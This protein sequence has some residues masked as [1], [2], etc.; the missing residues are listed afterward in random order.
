MLTPTGP[1]WG[2]LCRLERTGASG[3]TGIGSGEHAGRFGLLKFEV[4]APGGASTEMGH[5]QK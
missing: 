4:K 1:R 3:H 5:V 2:R